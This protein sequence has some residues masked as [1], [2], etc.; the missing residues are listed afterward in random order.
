[1]TNNGRESSP[2]KSASEILCANLAQGMH[3][4]AQ[5]LAVLLASLGKDQ[6]NGMDT[7]ELRELT[8]SSAVQVQRV[9]TLFGCLQH[10]V[11]A[12]S[13]KPQLSPTPILPLLAHAGEGVN[14]L[15]Q[16]DGISLTSKVPDTCQPVLID[17]ARTLHALSRVLQIAHTVS[18]PRDTVELIASS[19]ANRVQI[20]VRNANSAVA[21]I[22]ADETLSM[23][24]AEAN[25]RSQQAGF[26]WSLQPFNVLI[27]FQ[28]APLLYESSNPAVLSIT[29][30][31]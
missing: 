5:P 11:I 25:I 2:P 31:N 20:V 19:S 12:E 21:A 28:K 24:V 29:E 22:T 15:F 9:C 13:I 23:A 14:L 3:A 27:E 7:R 30:A 26:S 10:L 17:R 6:T 16:L 18:R 8:G 4:V 1:M